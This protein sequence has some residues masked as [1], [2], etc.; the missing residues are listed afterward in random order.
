M[1]VCKRWSVCVC[2]RVCVLKCVC[3]QAR[4]RACAASLCLCVCVCV[5]AC[6]CV[7]VCFFA[8][9]L[10]YLCVYKITHLQCGELCACVNSNVQYIH[11]RLH[12]SL[13]CFEALRL[14]PHVSHMYM[15][16]PSSS[17]L[18]QNDSRHSNRSTL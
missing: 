16:S 13:S 12:T 2:V 6:L 10:A 5:R 1:C 3:A 17:S 7:L 15:L 18:A 4:V 11:R 14:H 8:G 9:V